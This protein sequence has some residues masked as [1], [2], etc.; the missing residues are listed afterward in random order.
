M[1]KR[2][3]S[4]VEMVLAFLIFIGAVLF[5]IYFFAGQFSQR[6][7]SESID[8]IYNV[9]I[10]NAKDEFKTYSI[11]VNRTS[12]PSQVEIIAIDLDVDFN[13]DENVA[14]YDFSENKIPLKLIS[15]IIYLNISDS[16][17][18][19]NLRISK[20]ILNNYTQ[21]SDS[22]THNPSNYEIA[23]STRNTLTSEKMLRDLIREY[24]LDYNRLKSRLGVSRGF[25]FGFGVKFSET[26][27]MET[28]K[29]IPKQVQLFTKNE[30]KE[31]L[32]E[33]GRV[34]FS[35]FKVSVW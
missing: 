2:G 16:E 11:K 21:F 5:A 29:E 35:D 34:L 7:K 4:N 6:E 13:L 9:I 27:F 12:L 22:P 8:Y 23:S 19:I 31:I 25:E 10:D 32:K 1:E 26:E 18:I 20:S 14:A 33:D 28:N 17:D 24:N 30:R 3:I 15:D